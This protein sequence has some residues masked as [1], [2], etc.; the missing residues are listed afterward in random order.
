[1]VRRRNPRSLQIPLTAMYRGKRYDLWAGKS[2]PAGWH[3]RS[4]AQMAAR[5]LRKKGWMAFV[6]TFYGVDSRG[7]KEEW[8]AIYRRKK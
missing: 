4:D 6:K 2:G 5:D 7:M 8:Y 1:M 3:T